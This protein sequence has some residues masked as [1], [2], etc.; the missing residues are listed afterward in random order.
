[1]QF[2]LAAWIS[3]TVGLNI[4][5]DSGGLGP[6]AARAPREPR[7]AAPGSSRGDGVKTPSERYAALTRVEH[8]AADDRLRE[9]MG[10]KMARWLGRESPGRPRKRVE[11]EAADG[12]R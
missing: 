7:A 8:M 4:I 12:R 3:L 1:M 11:A 6:S 5:L 10:R 2:T 9:E